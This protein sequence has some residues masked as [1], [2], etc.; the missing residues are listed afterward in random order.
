MGGT[1]GC[2][3]FKP[4]FDLFLAPSDLLANT[5]SQRADDLLGQQ[6]CTAA[7]PVGKGLCVSW[8]VQLLSFTQNARE[9]LTSMSHRVFLCLLSTKCFVFPEMGVNISS[10]ISG[11]N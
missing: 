4:M 9:D 2:C 6:L 10:G 11:G 7:V 5:W 3:L 8:A 1:Q